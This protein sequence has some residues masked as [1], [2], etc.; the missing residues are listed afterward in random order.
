MSLTIHTNSGLS[1]LMQS[2]IAAA[3]TI[4]AATNADPGVF[5]S[6]T[7]GYSDGDLI[8]L[9]VEGMTEVN[10]RVFQVYASDATTFKLE[11]VDGASGIDTTG[12]GV[13]ISG[14]AKK[15]TMGTSVVGVQDFSPSGGEP[16]YLDTTTVHD[17]NDR[18]IVSGASAMSYSLTL[19]WDPANAAQVA[20]LAAYKAAAAKAFKITWPNGR[21]VMFYGT[22]GF[23]GMPGGGKQAVTT[24]TCGIALEADPTFGS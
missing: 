6:A 14:T 17:L 20:M 1:M 12:F 22:V 2:A 19:Q 11:D 23:S 8:L 3:K 10:E 4:T 24:V 5:T 16:K 21:T 7:H 13:F 9:Q 18:Q 15:L